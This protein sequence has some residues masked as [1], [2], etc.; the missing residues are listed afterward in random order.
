MRLG[1]RPEDLGR[2]GEHTVELVVQRTESLGSETLAYLEAGGERPVIARFDRRADLRVGMPARI[3]VDLDRLYF[4]D[5]RS[6]AA[7]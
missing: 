5:R 6:G 7:L 1:L 4:F 2:D 3:P